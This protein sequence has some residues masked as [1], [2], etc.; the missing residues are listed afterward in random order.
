MRNDETLTQLVAGRVGGAGKMS[1]DEFSERAVDPDSKTRPSRTTLWKVQQ[2]KPI[3]VNPIVVGAIAA[4]LGL[5]PVRVSRAAARQYIGPAA[6]DPWPDEHHPDIGVAV[7]R[8]EGMTGRDLP[9][10]HRKV[11]AVIDELDGLDS[12]TQ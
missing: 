6:T 10:T 5:D 3:M 8:A 9:R 12:N 2:G 1:F 11:R 7:A 4:G